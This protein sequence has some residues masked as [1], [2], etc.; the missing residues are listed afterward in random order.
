MDRRA[1]VE[2]HAPYVRSI[3]GKIKK[4]VPSEISFE[5]LYDYGIIGLLEAADRFDP[6]QGVAFTTYAYYRIRGAIYDGLRRMGWMS[7]SAYAKARFEARANAYLEEAASHPHGEGDPPADPKASSPPSAPPKDEDARHPLEV[8]VEDLATVVRS[9]AAVY[10]TSLD[11]ATEAKLI[12][13]SQL[14]P[15]ETV[16]LEELRTLVRKTIRRLSPEE[17][18]L[19]ELYYYKDKS[20]QQVGD[21]LGLS[22]SWT[23]RLHARVIDKLHRMLEE[24]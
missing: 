6:S 21:Q 9:L 12:D 16:G 1:L 8:A 11:A 2:L 13:E 20:M 14:G 3:V 24:P 18:Q 23:S 7:R 15:E 4:S 10:I 22:K 17:R 19:L 5:E